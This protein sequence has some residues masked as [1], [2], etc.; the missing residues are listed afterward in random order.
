MWESKDGLN[1]EGRTRETE[2][3]QRRKQ[4]K[5]RNWNRNIGNIINLCMNTNVF[6]GIVKIYA[7]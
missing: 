7:S 4:N 5:N 3:I 6:K 1:I 2:V